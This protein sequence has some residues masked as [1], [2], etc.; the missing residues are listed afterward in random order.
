MFGEEISA[1]IPPKRRP[2]DKKGHKK[3]ATTWNYFS[4]SASYARISRRD[5]ETSFTQV[6]AEKRVE[7]GK[8]PRET[9]KKQFW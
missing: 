3:T 9:I 5:C 1:K 8:V 7:K 4:N 2:A 6:L